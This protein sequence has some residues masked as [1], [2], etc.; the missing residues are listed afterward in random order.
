MQIQK[1][2]QN[3]KED[4]LEEEKLKILQ[5]HLP[6]IKDFCDLELKKEFDKL[7]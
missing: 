2:K 4:W 5:E 1:E 6:Y 7:K 3:I